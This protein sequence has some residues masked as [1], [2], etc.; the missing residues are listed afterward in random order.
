MSGNRGRPKLSNS[1][2]IFKV[3]GTPFFDV[4]NHTLGVE[5]HRKMKAAKNTSCATVVQQITSEDATVTH[6]FHILKGWND[7]YYLSKDSRPAPRE[8]HEQLQGSLPR[9]V[10]VG[11]QGLVFRCGKGEDPAMLSDYTM[12]VHIKRLN[13]R[14]T[15][16]Y[17]E[18]NQPLYLQDHSC[19]SPTKAVQRLTQV[20]HLFLKQPSVIQPENVR[21]VLKLMQR[22]FVAKVLELLTI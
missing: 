17:A 4:I 1:C 19:P 15:L 3:S 5:T 16:H 11:G 18:H 14:M 12:P 8:H 20:A 7:V 13:L 2:L 10:Q 21:P 22:P 9:Q 6:A